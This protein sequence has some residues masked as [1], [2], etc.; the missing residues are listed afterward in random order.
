MIGTA[1]ASF[2]P[3]VPPEP[4]LEGFGYDMWLGPSPWAPFNMQRCI[5]N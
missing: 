2:R 5:F 3:D 1:T 4:V